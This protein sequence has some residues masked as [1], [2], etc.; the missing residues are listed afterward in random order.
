[1]LESIYQLL[2]Y[3]LLQENERVLNPY[4]LLFSTLVYAICLAISIG[5]TYRL[6]KA[7]SATE[8]KKDL[9]QPIFLMGLTFI[10][11]FAIHL[12]AQIL[13]AISG[14]A[15]TLQPAIN[16]FIPYI[17]RFAAS[18]FVLTTLVKI[19]KFRRKRLQLVK[20]L[21]IF[22]MLFS[23]LAIGIVYSP[24]YRG[25][26]P[27]G[28]A[29]FMIILLGWTLINVITFSLIILVLRR[30]G[31]DN[32]SKIGRLRIRMITYGFLGILLTFF[33]GPVLSMPN[34]T[35]IMSVVVSVFVAIYSGLLVVTVYAFY[36]SFFLPKWL[37][38]RAGL[39]FDPS[40]FQTQAKTTPT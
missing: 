5:I 8:T 19:P 21:L 11:T 12:T 26:T 34:P 4:F 32:S 13:R 31:L 36:I 3:L 10:V 27:E 14:D 23:T 37:R 20:G 33:I 9:V 22:A 17:I 1:M 18:L 38:K 30:E 29:T 15:V 24:L 40:I 7:M 39:Y 35:G 25:R 28:M 2:S 16:I 6:F